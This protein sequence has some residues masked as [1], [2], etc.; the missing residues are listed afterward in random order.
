VA[1]VLEVDAD[2]V[3][4]AGFGEEAEEAEVAEGLFDLP[5]GAGGAAVLGDDHELGVIGARGEG[6]VDFAGGIA[7]AADDQGEVF[8]LDRVV[9]ELVGEVALGV[10]VLGEEEDAGGVLVEAVDESEAG[11]GSAGGGEGELVAELFEDAGGFG[12]AGNCRQGRGLGD[13]EEVGGVEKNIHRKPEWRN[14]KSESMTNDE[15]RITKSE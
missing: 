2:L 6:G 12:A 3:G 11:V 4:L 5:E 9:L 7:G 13:G 8:L 10:D 14:P 1:D 15:I